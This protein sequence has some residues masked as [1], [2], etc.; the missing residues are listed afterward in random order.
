MFLELPRRDM[1]EEVVGLEGMA[2]MESVEDQLSWEVLRDCLG[3]SLYIV[4]GI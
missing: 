4:G 2:T 1:V 3:R